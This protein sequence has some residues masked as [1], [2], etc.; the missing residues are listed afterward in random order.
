L[1]SRSLSVI[2]ETLSQPSNQKYLDIN[3]EGT[4]LREAQDIA[5]EL[6]MMRRV[7]SQ[8]H[9]V[10]KDYRRHLGLLSGD[11]RYER[12]VLRS[13]LASLSQSLQEPGEQS[14][15]ISRPAAVKQPSQFDEAVQAADILLELIDNRQAELQD[16]EES[17]L[18]TCRQLEGLLGLKQQQASIVEAKAALRRA[19]ESVKQGRAI[20]AFALVTIFFV[21]FPGPRP[22]DGA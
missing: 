1:H 3:P 21:S 18:R 17:A 8:Q 2:V 11:V 15:V 10:V 9:Q 14:Q 22:K 7:F 12:D 20:M 19:D 5:E 4:L 13:V 6:K 16:L